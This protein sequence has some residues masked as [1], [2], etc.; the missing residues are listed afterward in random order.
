LAN[1]KKDKLQGELKRNN[2]CPNHNCDIPLDKHPECSM[3]GLLIG[4]KHLAV[5][6]YT[7]HKLCKWCVDSKRKHQPL[8]SAYCRNYTK[9]LCYNCD[10]VYSVPGLTQDTHCPK[11]GERLFN[12]EVPWLSD[13]AV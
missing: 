9:A 11:C 4:V 1:S 8:Y 6:T 5:K 7:K 3:C 10:E 12:I 13:E 2:Y